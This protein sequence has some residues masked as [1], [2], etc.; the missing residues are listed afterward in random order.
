M[1]TTLKEKYL[2]VSYSEILLT[3]SLFFN[4]ME[5][6]KE[7]RKA[8]DI[9]FL[10]LHIDERRKVKESIESFVLSQENELRKELQLPTFQ[11]YQRKEKLNDR[12]L[13]R[14][15]SKRMENKHYA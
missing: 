9:N 11:N 10:D 4:S 7:W 14:T 3:N 8:N 1:V 6:R 5:T 12:P 13:L 15:Y 2:V